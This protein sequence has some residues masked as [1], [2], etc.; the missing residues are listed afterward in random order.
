MCQLQKK[1]KTPIKSMGYLN[2]QGIY[3]PLNMPEVHFFHASQT[4]AEQKTKRNQC[5]AGMAR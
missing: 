1:L 2:F 4:N 5:N 3:L